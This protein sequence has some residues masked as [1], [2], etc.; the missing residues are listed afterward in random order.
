M[1]E[2]PEGTPTGDYLA[3]PSDLAQLTG[4]APDNADLLLALR[5][6]SDRFRDEVGH[7]VLLVEADTCYLSGRGGPALHLPARPISDVTVTIDGT[8]VPASAYQV[9]R[10]SGVLR[11]RTG[12]WPDGLDN[13]EVTYTHGY[14][15]V[16]PGIADAVLEAAELAITMTTGIESITTADES[17]KVANSLVNGGRTET[18]TKAVARY[19][20]GRGDRS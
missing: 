18:W 6:A 12:A 5:R 4:L 2:A 1:S 15:T 10:E 11:H 17:V 3:D 7:P 20:V 16:P 14:A 9:G 19:Q 13:I 8:E